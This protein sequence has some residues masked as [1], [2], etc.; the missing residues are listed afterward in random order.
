M[1][2]KTK[3]AIGPERTG[4]GTTTMVRWVPL[5]AVAEYLGVSRQK[6]R[7]LVQE[8]DLPEPS[9]QL[10]RRMPRWDI[11]EVEAAVKQVAR[12]YWMVEGRSPGA[13]QR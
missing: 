5:S 6:V 8:G 1:S 11:Q 2:A 9:Y 7:Q 13:W 12:W 3:V 4:E 10:G